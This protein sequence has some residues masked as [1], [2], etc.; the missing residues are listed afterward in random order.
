MIATLIDAIKKGWYSTW[1][2]LTTSR[3]QKHLEPSEHTSMGHMKM[4]SKGIKSTQPPKLTVDEPNEP[5][6]PPVPITV[7]TD[8]I[9]DVY[10][11]CYDNPLY[12]DRNVFGVDPPG[13]YQKESGLL[14]QN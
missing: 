1:L 14:N 6:P 12:D 10:I 11:H 9:H 3:V 4:I 5:E 7:P 8:N 2:G 13:R